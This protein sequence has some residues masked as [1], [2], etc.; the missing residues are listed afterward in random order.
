[1]AFIYRNEVASSYGSILLYVCCMNVSD[2]QC[3]YDARW[4]I[5]R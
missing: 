4:I 1:M 3:R 5:Q 2:P